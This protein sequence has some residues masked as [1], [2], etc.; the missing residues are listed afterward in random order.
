LENTGIL[1]EG[2]LTD[3]ANNVHT[4][5]SII[6]NLLKNNRKVVFRNLARAL[7]SLRQPSQPAQGI[8]K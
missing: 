3:H 1:H 6:R 2:Q 7:Q 5:G 4:D 8:E